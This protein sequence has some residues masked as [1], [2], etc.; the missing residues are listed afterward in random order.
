MWSG[1]V[2]FLFLRAPALV[3][4]SLSSQLIGLCE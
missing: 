4:H 3:A 1:N 2:I